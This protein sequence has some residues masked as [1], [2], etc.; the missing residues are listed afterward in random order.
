MAA[1][2]DVI[3]VRWQTYQPGCGMVCPQLFAPWS[4]TCTRACALHMAP[5]SFGP[6]GMCRFSWRDGQ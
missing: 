4:A 5:L 1:D 2:F 3:L 6:C